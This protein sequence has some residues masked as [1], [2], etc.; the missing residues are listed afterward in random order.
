MHQTRSGRQQWI[1]GIILG[2]ALS[3]LPVWAYAL[4]LG[5]L[6]VRS[7]LDEP[8]NGEID[9]IDPTPQ[10]LKTLS[11]SLAS[12][13]DFDDAGIDRPSFL[14]TIKYAI[15]QHKNGSYYIRLTTD[16][17]IDEPFIHT[18]LQVDWAG[19]HL[20]REYTALL[21]PPHWVAGE[22]PEIE[23][24]AVAETVPAPVPAPAP[25]PVTAEQPAVAGTAPV[26]AESTKAEQTKTPETASTETP[27]SAGAPAPAQGGLLGP[28]VADTGTA[29]VPEE[30]PV[31]S[32]PAAATETGTPRSSWANAA[33]YTVRKGDTLSGITRKLTADPNISPQQVMIALLRTNPGA[34]FGHNINNLKAG[35]ILRVPDRAAVQAVSKVRADK[36]Y[37]VQFDAWQEYKLKLAA[38]S[39]TVT[40]PGE[41]ATE[42][43][44]TAKGA[45]SKVPTAAKSSAAQGK[46]APAEAA[47]TAAA[48]TATTTA[49]GTASGAAGEDLLQIV[50]SSLNTESDGGGAGKASGPSSAKTEAAGERHALTSKVATLEEQIDAKQLENKNL[51]ERVG[52]MQEQVKNTARLIDIENK[53]L[54]VSQ[55]QAAKPAPSAPASQLASAPSAQPKPAVHKPVVPPAV[56]KPLPRRFVVPPPESPGLVQS[57]IDSITGNSVRMALLGGVGILGLGILGMYYMRRRRAKAEFEESILSGGS[58]PADGASITES[59]SQ[60]AAS[61]TSFL[62]DFSQGGMGNVHT[63]EVDPIAEAEVYL[64]YGRDEQAEEILREAIVK[65]PQRQELKQKLLEIYHQRN[66]A[67]AF[68]TL[69]EEL[70]AQVEGKGGKIWEKVEEMGRKISPA[71]PMFRGGAPDPKSNPTAAA[72]KVVA[73]AGTTGPFETESSILEMNDTLGMSAPKTPPAAAAGGMNYDFDAPAAPATPSSSEVSF[74]LDLA[75]DSPADAPAAAV[76]A[77]VSA[78]PADSSFDLNFSLDDSEPAAGSNMISFDTAPVSESE[79]TLDF[80]ST[81]VARA[82]E[83]IAF[84]LDSASESPVLEFENVSEGSAETGEGGQSQWDETATKLD[85]AKA[86][87]DMGDAEGARSILDEVMAE[88]NDSQKNQ[89]RELAAQIA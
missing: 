20:I 60:A 82:D 25:A 32:T 16:A 58:L 63:D 13:S 69:A 3:L 50:R 30:G 12:R 66:D 70:Y 87:I 29:A 64:A 85:L 68:E 51:R 77:P 42:S 54:A 44:A 89:A 4:G 75:A 37:R 67:G 26:A 57:I 28:S 6:V 43:G 88:G 14:S 73:K 45:V 59:G 27:A 40:V 2:A 21:D 49:A 1:A 52:K 36:D 62:S 83:G 9:I 61:D 86:Y 31:E 8:L 7:G 84:A 38:A 41:S 78:A 34:F 19:G 71:N 17:P 47:R 22:Q 56:K 65:D 18:L 11:P 76:P 80:H 48:K 79:P 81:D 15:A 23:A 24:P 35:R 10:E 74:D 53:E 39:H 46:A 33:H 5:R 72:S 55:N